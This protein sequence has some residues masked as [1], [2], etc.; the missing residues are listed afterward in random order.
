MYIEEF[1]NNGGSPLAVLLMVYSYYVMKTAKLHILNDYLKV[2]IILKHPTAEF[3]ILF[4]LPGLAL[5][6]IY[7]GLFSEW[8]AGMFSFFAL[9][10]IGK[11]GAKILGVHTYK[12]FGWHYIMACIAI[13]VGYFIS[14]STF[15]M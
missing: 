15:I 11:W 4:A 7:I 13:P 3:F 8:I 6:A 12:F 2:P 10:F 14:I 9:M 5:S 1:L